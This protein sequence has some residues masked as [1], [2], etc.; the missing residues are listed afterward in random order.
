M[1]AAEDPKVIDERQPDKFMAHF[2]WRIFH[3]PGRKVDRVI[4]EGDEVA[5][6]QV[7]D[8]RRATPP[9]TSPSGASRTGC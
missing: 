5:G 7:I 9:A 6:F 3:G 8:V 1:P 2:F 4:K